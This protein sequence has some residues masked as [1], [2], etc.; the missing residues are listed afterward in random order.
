MVLLVTL[1][2]AFGVFGNNPVSTMLNAVVGWLP[3][4]IGCRR[5]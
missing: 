5:R 2:L 3:K 4:A 1:Q